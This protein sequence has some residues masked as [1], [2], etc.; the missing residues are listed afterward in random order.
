M[1]GNSEQVSFRFIANKIQQKKIFIHHSYFRI[2]SFYS[3]LHVKIRKVPINP[4]KSLFFHPG[5]I[6]TSDESATQCYV[7]STIQAILIH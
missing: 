5:N 7:A 3:S 4:E 6:E 2:Q 1:F